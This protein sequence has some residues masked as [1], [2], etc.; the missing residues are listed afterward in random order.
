MKQTDRARGIKVLL[1]ILLTYVEENP[2]LVTNNHYGLCDIMHCI[3]LDNVEYSGFPKSIESV[4]LITNKEKNKLIDYLRYNRPEPIMDGHSVDLFYWTS[5]N[6][7]L[8]INWLKEQI[9]KQR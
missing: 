3:T 9:K 6:V 2:T 4:D 5:G 1:Q 8:R 7:E